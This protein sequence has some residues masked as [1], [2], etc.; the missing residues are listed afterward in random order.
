MS[1]SGSKKSAAS[2]SETKPKASPARRLGIFIKPSTVGKALRQEFRGARLS[3]DAAKYLAISLDAIAKDIVSIS[4]E[5]VMDHKQKTLT[6]KN[7]KS[8]IDNDVDHKVV[9]GNFIFHR[10]SVAGSHIDAERIRK[11]VERSRR[12]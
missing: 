11:L 7:L 5:D 6:S 2:T 8:A 9:F 1:S 10:S 3:A 4:I 12:A